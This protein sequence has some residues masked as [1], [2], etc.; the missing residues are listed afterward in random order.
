MSSDVSVSAALTTVRSQYIERRAFRG[1]G[2]PSDAAREYRRYAR[3]SVITADVS[4]A[5]WWLPDQ[6]GAD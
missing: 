1:P 6:L 5:A 4:P 3:A 2:F